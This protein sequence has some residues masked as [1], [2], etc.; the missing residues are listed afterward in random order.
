MNFDKLNLS[1]VG[2]LLQSGRCFAALVYCLVM[3]HGCRLH[4]AALTTSAQSRCGLLQADWRTG[5]RA[6]SSGQ[7]PSRKPFRLF[8]EKRTALNLFVGAAA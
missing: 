1:A 6:A 5:S 7:P 3:R 8:D 4:C 2:W